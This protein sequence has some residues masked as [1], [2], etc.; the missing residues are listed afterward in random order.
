MIRS[1]IYRYTQ[2]T[3]L[4]TFASRILLKLNL[5]IVLC[6]L[7]AACSMVDRPEYE[8]GYGKTI[9]VQGTIMTRATVTPEAA[10]TDYELINDWWVLFV[11]N[12]NKI[13]K[14]LDRATA[15]GNKNAVEEERFYLE[16]PAGKYTAYS[17]A[18]VT[19]S[20]IENLAGSLQEGDNLPAGFDNLTFNI[21]NVI[22][23]GH[24]FEGNDRLIPMTGKQEEVT[25][26]NQGEA[27]VKL[28]VI[29]MVAKL[30]FRYK[31][32]SGKEITL[33]SIKMQQSN[34]DVVSLLPNYTYL[35]SGWPI[36]ETTGDTR[37]YIRPIGQQL[38]KSYSGAAP[39]YTDKFYMIEAQAT[40]NPAKRFT[41]ALNITREGGKTEEMLYAMTQELESYYRNDH[42]VIP[43][44]IS[45]YAIDVDVN[46]YP[47]IGGYPAVIT[48]NSKEE[49]YCEFATQG[50]FVIRPK[51]VD[52]SNNYRLVYETGDP[53]FVYRLTAVSDPSDIFSVDPHIEE[54][55]GELLGCLGT[56]QGT[57]IVDL[58]ITVK[59]NA[60]ADQIYNR[61]IYIIRKN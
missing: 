40:T 23:N 15:T 54:G 8:E 53:H 21:G 6:T 33:N 60:V 39:Q 12:N 41:L 35:D 29:R 43:I 38:S 11:D 17:F 5:G 36:G 48:T 1:L 51:V 14:Y 61:R 52:T 24:N 25:F 56:N 2:N 28:E 37:D 45:D 31:N 49:F 59:R 47:P 50:N 16:I 13:V 10:E 58:E 27:D 19:R 26:Q 3:N 9:A 4:S 46:F 22:P 42:V 30:E 32:A 34:T 20:T 7:L 44:T 55:T 57:A 18:N